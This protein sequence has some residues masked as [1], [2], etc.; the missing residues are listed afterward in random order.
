MWDY[1][2][3]LVRIT[4]LFKSLKHSKVSRLPGMHVNVL[5]VSVDDAS[6]S[7]DSKSSSP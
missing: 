5:N 3:G 4:A 7:H 1:N 2:V 6:K